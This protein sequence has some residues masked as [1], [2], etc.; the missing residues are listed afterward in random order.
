V[1]GQAVGRGRG[2]TLARGEQIGAEGPIGVLTARRSFASA[3]A[4]VSSIVHPDGAQLTS[5]P[6]WVAGHER[7]PEA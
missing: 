6:D 4:T 2:G 7:I 5:R 3:G 1:S